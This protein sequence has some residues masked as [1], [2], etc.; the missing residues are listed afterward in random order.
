MIGGSVV[1][2]G[3]YTDPSYASTVQGALRSG[4]RAAAALLEAGRGPRVVVIGAGIA[5]LGAADALAAAGAEVAVLEAQGRIGGRVRTDMSMGVPVELGAAWMHALTGNPLVPLAQEAGLRLVPTDYDDEVFRDTVTGRPSRAAAR[6][7]ADTVTLMRELEESW[8]DP[9]TSVAQWLARRGLPA[10]RF[11]RWAVQTEVVQEFAL[12]AARLGSRA[13]TEGAEYRGGDAFVAGGYDRIATLLAEGIDIRLGTAVQSVDASRRDRVEV[14]TQGGDRMAADAVVVAVPVSLLR[15]GLPRISPMPAAVRSALGG[16][17]TGDLEKV[18]LRYDE[19][20]WGPE[21]L[22]GI[23]GGGVPGQSALASLRWTEFYDVT[24]VLGVPA[25]VGFSGG[26][27]AR[28]RPRSDAACV[29]EAQAA[30][31]AAFSS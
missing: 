20:W 21:R 27:P 16:L 23:V 1:L 19:R 24:D 17:R 12:D 28:R 5:G 26:S 8:P 30:L 4:R 13:P 18:I 31:Q 11:T 14:L 9:D 6:A 2:A 15:A 7:S 10:T 25:L 29:A 3:E 22:M